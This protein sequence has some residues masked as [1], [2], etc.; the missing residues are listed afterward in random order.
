MMESMIEESDAK[1]RLVHVGGSS[2]DPF[3][4]GESSVR[5]HSVWVG[6]HHRQCEGLPAVIRDS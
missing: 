4:V 5:V 2:C 6:P 1:R 3:H